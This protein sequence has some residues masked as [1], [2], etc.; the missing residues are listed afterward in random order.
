MEWLWELLSRQLASNQFFSGGL[1][2]MVSGRPGG[3]LRTCA[4][5]NLG[6]GSRTACLIEIDIPD[7]EA[8]FEWLDKWLAAHAYSQRRARR[9]TVRVQH[10][11]YRE[12]A[13]DPAGDHRPRVLFSP[14]PGEHWLWY[15]GR[16]VILNRQRAD[17]EKNAP[18]AGP[19]VPPR[20]LQHHDRQPQ[21]GAGLATARRRPRPRPAAE[22]P[23]G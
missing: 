17:T 15:R 3:G 14:A 23:A 9:L 4:R 8:A 16:L 1:I 6:L 11:D 18:G 19:A 5:Q 7:R 2:L 21:P 12:R 20:D 13:A 22:R 10:P